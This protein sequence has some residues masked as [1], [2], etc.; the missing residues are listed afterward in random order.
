MNLKTILSKLPFWQENTTTSESLSLQKENAEPTGLKYIDPI[1]VTWAAGLFEGE[2]SIRKSNNKWSI[3]VEMTDKD[4]VERFA[5][6][7]DLKVYGP[8]QRKRP[9]KDGSPSK[10]SW[11]AKATARDKVFA[12]VAELYPELGERRRSKCDEF[13]DWYE[14]INRR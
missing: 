10:P 14:N 7:F 3:G 5:A 9:L 13:V 4:V 8:Y 11:E 6:V 2:G 1:E 12:I